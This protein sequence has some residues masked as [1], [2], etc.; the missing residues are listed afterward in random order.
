MW[1]LRCNT[2]RW[3]VLHCVVALLASLIILGATTGC[4]GDPQAGEFQTLDG[5]W[6]LAELRVSESDVTTVLQSRYEELPTLAI[7]GAVDPPRYELRGT[8]TAEQSQPPLFIEG[9]IEV[10]QSNTMVWITGF[11]RDVIWRFEVQTTGRIT[12]TAEPGPF[13]AAPVLDALIPDFNWAD[14][15]RVVLRLERTFP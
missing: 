8:P 1:K 10:P 4:S 3:S 13:N 9:R 11:E 15:D 12:L 2:L 14:M 5:A 7:E 6:T